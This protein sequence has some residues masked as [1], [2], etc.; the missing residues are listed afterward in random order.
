MITKMQSLNDDLDNDPYEQ[1]II[2]AM[3]KE[4]YKTK[5]KEKIHSIAKMYSGE[6]NEQ[7]FNNYIDY[8]YES[9]YLQYFKWVSYHSKGEIDFVIQL[10]DL[11][12]I[13]IDVIG[14]HM[15]GDHIMLNCNSK[16]YKTKLKAFNGHRGYLA[17]ELNGEWRFLQVSRHLPKGD[18][19]LGSGRNKHIKKAGYVFHD[20][21]IPG[22]TPIQSNNNS[23]ND[24][25]RHM[26]NIAHS[27]ML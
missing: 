26:I 17:F 12:T 18:I 19:M 22:N 2:N 3:Q 24:S 16:N 21:S 14:T 7:R 9:G 23:C 10:K 13:F 5:R 6:V 15:R 4:Y 27:Q 8:L 1:A 25:G 11:D 20:E